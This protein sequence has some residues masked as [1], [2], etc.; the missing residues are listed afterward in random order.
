[1]SNR[2]T[3]IDRRGA[4]AAAVGLMLAPRQAA[5]ATAERAGAV[6]RV[7]GEASATAGPVQR[8]L[9][10]NDPIMVD[11]LIRTS[12]GA[13]LDLRLGLRTVLKLADATEIKIDRYLLDAGGEI[14][15]LGGAVLFER[16]GKRAGE[17]LQ[18]RSVY[19]LIAVRGTRFYA[20][21]HRDRFAVLVGHGRVE[22]TA[23]GRS[24]SVGPQ[25]GVD[26][27]SP[28]AAPTTPANWGLAR[29]RDFQ[30]R[31]K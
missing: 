17:D 22:V 21:L 2:S 15:L 6:E 31:F 12:A 26:I 18:F 29:I 20:G 23:G 14:S 1:M 19:G 10:L 27:P 3:F 11:D 13:Q 8:P 30:A 9:G 25:Q 16:T 5:A 28:G 7:V 4:I 24:V